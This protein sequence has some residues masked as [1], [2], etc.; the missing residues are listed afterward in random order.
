MKK[1]LFFLLIAATISCSTFAQDISG[2]WSGSL[3]VG[4]KLRLV[5]TIELNNGIYTTTMDSPD[6]GVKGIPTSATSFE[7]Q[8]LTISIQALN[9]SYK[10]RLENDSIKGT[11]T[12]SGAS[13]PLLLTKGEVAEIRRPQDPQTPFSYQSEDIRFENRKANITLAGTL[14]YPK[15]G[16][17]FSA[18][19]LVSGSGAQNRN[20]EILNHRP[21]LVLSDYL[22]RNGIAVLRYDDR[23]TAESGGTY[24]TASM[25]D[26]ATD[27]EAAIEYLKTKNEINSNKIGVIGHSEGGTIAFILAGEN[28]NLAFIVSMA[29]A[30]I[31]GDSLMKEQRYMIGKASGL[32]DEA[33]AANEELVATLYNIVETHSA[34]FILAHINEL[35]EELLPEDE[36]LK[37]IARKMYQQE[38]SR[39]LSPEILSIIKFDPTNSLQNITCPV[40]ALNGDK[41]LQVAADA[42]LEQVEKLVKSS[43]TTKKYANLNH[44]FQPCETGLI[45]EYSVIETTISPE[46][47]KDISDWILNVTK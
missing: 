44:L 12:Q 42:N 27:A 37:E 40:L 8:E 25:Q 21:F 23:G 34:E 31:K 46:V 9:A 6:Q 14:T 15:S 20:S 1:Y 38:I 26:F 22:T 10:G 43:V 45:N 41:D 30:A 13:F 18:V 39:F 28:N 7:N 4:I 33:I 5:F 16:N 19:I 47:L 35:I 32:S 24:A 3:N 2:S 17:N 36:Q 29:G 11:F